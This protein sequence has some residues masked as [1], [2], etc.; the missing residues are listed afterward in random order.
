MKISYLK[1]IGI[2]IPSL[3]ITLLSFPLII[4]A[5]SQTIIE[6]GKFSA[7]AGRQNSKLFLV[8]KSLGN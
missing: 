1:G 3:L 5:Q 2:I 6:A 4:H 7:T 8:I